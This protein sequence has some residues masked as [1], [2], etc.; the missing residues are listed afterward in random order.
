M[1]IRKGTQKDIDEL[2]A[3]Y[4]E[5][6]DYLEHHINYPGWRKGI[7][8][9][10]EDAVCGI[11]EGN[12]FVAVIEG[13]IAGTVILR[14]RPEKGY[15]LVDWKNHFDYS[16]I[17]TIYTFAVHPQFLGNGIGKKI[18]EFILEYAAQMKMKAVRLDVYE[19]KYSVDSFI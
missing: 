19:K 15:E 12:L 17:F 13:K 14:H 10:R 8:P 5:L 6:N 7:Y 1:Q 18:M 3:L 11:E 9:A 2:S 4:D 16:E